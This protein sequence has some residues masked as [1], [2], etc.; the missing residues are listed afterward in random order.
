MHVMIVKF[1][2]TYTL[3]YM[4]KERSDITF[5]WLQYI[6]NNSPAPQQAQSNE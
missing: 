4:M 2:V 3:M 1:C 6:E 5:P